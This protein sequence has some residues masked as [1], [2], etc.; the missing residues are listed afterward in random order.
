MEGGFEQKGA[1]EKRA[2]SKQR[3]LHPVSDTEHPAAGDPGCRCS[4]CVDRRPVVLPDALIRDL[5]TG[6][7]V[8]FAGAGVSTESRLAYPTTF[9]ETLV[10]ELELTPQSGLSFSQAASA[11]CDRFGRQ[12]FLLTL[13]ERFERINAFPELWGM[14]T[15]FHH[16]L[17]PIPFVET[18]ITTNWDTYFEDHCSSLPLVTAE[19][20]AF[21]DFPARKVLKIHGSM[22]NVGTIVATER[23]H[24]RCYRRLRDGA[25][26][27]TMKHLLAT[28][29]VLFAGYSL[30][31]PDFQRIYRYLKREMKE[32]LPR[33]YL[34]TIDDSVDEERLGVRAR[35]LTDATH[36]I[37]LIKNQLVADGL[38][39]SDQ[40]HGDI[41]ACHEAVREVHSLLHKDLPPSANPDVIYTASYQDGLMHALSRALALWSS[42]Q[43]CSPPMLLQAIA[44]Y[45]S[46]R[47]GAQS[48]EVY[49]DVSYTDG[50]L[51]GLQYLLDG[52]KPPMLYV[53]GSSSS[54]F[55]RESFTEEL[56]RAAD[57][58]KK[59][60]DQAALIVAA[61]PV[62][63]EFYHPPHFG[64]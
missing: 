34:V 44:E 64:V 35:L 37:E 39:L 1:E 14:A 45:K 56:S 32:V 59:A 38:M 46:M 43:Y 20:L 13:K 61:A 27:A 49:W 48:A 33:S 58:H 29:S 40:R 60:H 7:L 18:I 26:G 50:Y 53:Y 6:S 28:K 51:A 19:D 31:D 55:N 22:A 2:S 23:D 16:A 63:R 42:G 41:Y 15:R 21:W 3:S 25:L 17:A 36:L 12:T 24:D 52:E 9:Y 62:G 30:G 57:I 11:F 8:I 10:S 5:A 47:G 4:F 54:L